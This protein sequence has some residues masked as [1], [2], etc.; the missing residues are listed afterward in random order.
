MLQVCIKSE[1]LQQIPSK[2][3]N[4]S[5]RGVFLSLPNQVMRR[6]PGKELLRTDLVWVLMEDTKSCILKDFVSLGSKQNYVGS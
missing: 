2:T 6:K 5:K 1:Q 4:Q 3:Y